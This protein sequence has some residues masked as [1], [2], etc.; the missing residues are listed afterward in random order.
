MGL[1]YGCAVLTVVSRVRPEAG[2]DEGRRGAG[3]TQTEPEGVSAVP[4]GG[5]GG[6]NGL[7]FS[8]TLGRSGLARPAAQLQ[9][10]GSARVGTGRKVGPRIPI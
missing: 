1:F 10:L 4:A 7:G 9:L 3:G 8:R 2:D 5:V 6:R